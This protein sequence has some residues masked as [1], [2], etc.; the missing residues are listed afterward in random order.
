MDKPYIKLLKTVEDKT[1]KFQVWEV[2]GEYIRNNIDV[3][4]TNYGQHYRFNFIPEKEFWID[5]EST[6]GEV[7]FFILRLMVEYYTMRIGKPYSVAVDTANKIEKQERFNS[8]KYKQVFGDRQPENINYNIRKKYLG[9]VKGTDIKVYIVDGEL[10]RD[11]YYIDFTQG[12]HD[13]VYKWIPPKEIWIDDDLKESEIM[14]T[15]IHEY[16]ERKF[17]E[18]GIDYPTAHKH[19]LKIEYKYRHKQKDTTLRRTE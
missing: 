11:V 8:K 3:D 6:P 10:I 17:M 12:G 1:D 2:D 5:I 14:Y 7:E 16:V 4:F 13:L 15:I 19:A 9:R 18:K